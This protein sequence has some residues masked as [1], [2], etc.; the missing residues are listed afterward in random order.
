VNS[1]TME[2]DECI[3]K[4][5]Q[6]SLS[7]VSDWI[8]LR[9]AKA[10]YFV[11][12]NVPGLIAL[13]PSY[14]IMDTLSQ[15]YAS[16]GIILQDKASCIPPCLL[17]AGRGNTVLDACAAPGNKTAQLAASVGPSGHVFAVERDSKRAITLK[18][19]M[20]KAGASKCNFLD[21]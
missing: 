21:I 7:P 11:D 2:F 8:G 17:D 18:N 4:L 19:M 15:D 16:G 3:E 13:R 6:L 5:K 14:P 20:D 1:I 12:P 10:G 9:E